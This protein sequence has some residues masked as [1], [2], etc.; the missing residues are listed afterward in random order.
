MALL[1]VGA[2][3]ILY[4]LIGTALPIYLHVEQHGRLNIV[5]AILSFFLSL[6]I[7]ICLWEISLGLNITLIK[8]D[9][10]SLKKKYKHDNWGA[11]VDLFLEPLTFSKLFSLRF[12]SKIWSTYSL[13]D[14]SYSNRESF[15]FFVDVGNGWLVA[16]F[17]LFSLL[18]LLALDT[19]QHFPLFI[20]V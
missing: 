8:K 17:C 19:P 5:Q 13:Y 4:V 10:E 16:D 2:F 11:V 7:L 14:P 1:N 18:S 6:N 15:G 3:L 9:F 12:W 20:V